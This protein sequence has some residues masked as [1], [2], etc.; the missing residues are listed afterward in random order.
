M[1]NAALQQEIVFAM[2]RFPFVTIESQLDLDS[3]VFLPYN[4][5][6]QVRAER[7]YPLTVALY[8]VRRESVNEKHIQQ[9]LEIEKQ[10]QEMYEKAVKDA[11]QLPVTAE[12][13]AQALIA[14]AKAEAEEEARR[15]LAEAQAEDRANEVLA[16]VERQKA[17]LEAKANANLDKAVAYVLERVIGRA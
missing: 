16:D 12:Q 9:V 13:E 5:A 10:A 2:P 7:R 6:V 1:S 15:I 14:K 11:Q 3:Q 8:V 17:E 4:S